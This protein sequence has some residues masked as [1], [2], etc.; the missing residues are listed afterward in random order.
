MADPT[1]AELFTQW[2]N[3][4]KVVDEVRRAAGG[5]SS[6]LNA[7]NATNTLGL[8]DTL[9]Q[10]YEGSFVAELATAAD[11]I[12]NGM[13][14]TISP[15]IIANGSRPILKT[16][17]EKVVARTDLSNDAE[18]FQE[19]YKYMHDNNL[20]VQSRVFTFGTPAATAN[21]NGTEQIVRLT[22][23]KFNYDIESGHVDSKRA[24]CIADE[25][26]GTGRGQEVW[27]VKGQSTARDELER[28][29]SGLRTLLT[30][31]TIDD[32]LL[33]NPGFRDV[34]LT[35]NSIT[36]WTSDVTINGTNY[37]DDTTNFFRA[38][39][40][41][42][43]PSSLVMNVSALL[44]QK[45]TVPGVELNDDIPYLLAVVYNAEV[46]TATGTLTARM[47]NVFNSVTVDGLTGWRV[48]LVPGSTGESN[49][50][51]LFAKDDMQLEV[52]FTRSTGTLNIGEVLFLPGTQFDGSWYWVLPA[53]QATYTPARVRDEFTWPDVATGTARNQTL[54]HRAFAGVYLPHSNGS[55]ISFTEA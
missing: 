24:L 42:G 27:E 38:A 25:N 12:R 17:L 43:T 54:I 6:S 11:A 51:R 13:A 9:E 50:Y 31:A 47:G 8:L 22:K 45:L 2:G 36:N 19:L 30:G 34:D 33:S 28:S 5:S 10:S 52:Q 53:N 20:Y 16:Y 32:S 37:S 23:D 48:L 35:N 21:N 39:P 14:A 41:D 3:F 4:L 29:G 26:T 1:S 44:S 40:S 46:G 7:P 49:W 18:M 55:S 15:S